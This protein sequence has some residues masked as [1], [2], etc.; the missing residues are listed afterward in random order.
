MAAS[1]LQDI[2]DILG[3]LVLVYDNVE[4]LVAKADKQQAEQTE[5]SLTKLHGFAADLL[6]ARRPAG[7]STPPRRPT[8]WGR[9][10]RSAPRRS[11]ARSPRPRRSSTSRSRRADQRVRRLGLHPA[12]AAALAG[13]GSPRQRGAALAGGAAHAGS[14]VFDAQT[15]L[16]LDE[17]RAAPRLVRRARAP[18]ARPA[19]ARPAPRRPGGP[20]RGARRAG[21]RAARGARTATRSALAAARGRLRAALLRGRYAVTVASV[22]AGDAERAATWLLLRE[23]RK[24]T[25]FTRPG[26][27]ATLAVRELGRGA[28]GPRKALLGVKKDLLDAYQ[29]ASPSSLTDA[30]DA[31][32]RGFGARWA[33]DRRRGRR[34]LGRSSRPSTSGRAAPRRR[35]EA[36]AAFAAL[37]DAARAGDARRLRGRPQ[38]RGGRPSTASPPPP[39]PPRSRRAAPGS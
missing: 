39:S 33:A 21:R 14:G 4:P 9:R 34:A 15:A 19:R 27:D 16:L 28:A 22:R 1:R 17:P 5:Q 13:G 36:D 30:E 38:R 7:A 3:G 31:A 26:V 24:A 6:R 11:P 8:R 18:A 10:R 25:R 32:E 2:A 20:P 12:L 37:E 29:A 23:F 35:A